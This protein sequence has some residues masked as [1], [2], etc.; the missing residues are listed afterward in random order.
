MLAIWRLSLGL[1]EILLNILIWS[2][3]LVVRMKRSE[4]V[5]TVNEEPIVPCWL[6]FHFHALVSRPHHRIIVLLYRREYCWGS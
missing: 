4:I 1:I 3:Y 2:T 6:M 5:D